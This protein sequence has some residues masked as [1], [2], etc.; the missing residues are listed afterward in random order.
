MLLTYKCVICC[1]RAVHMKKPN[2]A[3][4]LLLIIVV[5]NKMEM[6]LYHYLL[7][8]AYNTLSEKYF[9]FY[10]I[11]LIIL[12]NFVVTSELIIKIPPVYFRYFKMYL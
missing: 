6:I 3:V 11:K 1:C 7:N 12:I 4:D 2:N 10:F 9:R 5:K 8:T